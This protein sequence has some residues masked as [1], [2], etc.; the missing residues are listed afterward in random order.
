[1][2]VCLA[3]YALEGSEGLKSTLYEYERIANVF[4]K[5][6]FA[7]DVAVATTR[8]KK[9]WPETPPCYYDHP[10]PESRAPICF[11][12]F[13][14]PIGFTCMQTKKEI[15]LL[16]TR[17][18]EEIEL[19]GLEKQ[20]LYRTSGRLKDITDLCHS[21]ERD[22]LNTDI[23]ETDV[24][25]LCNVVK[26]YLRDLPYP[27]FPFYMSERLEYARELLCLIV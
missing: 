25:V 23:S 3:Y 8:L 13:G 27:L 21:L 16:L 26:L 18:I 7:E 5:A 22:L 12:S 15:P 14:V 9:L 20:G 17:L 4:K 10:A 1:M 2:N 11:L 24:S 6:S 19:R